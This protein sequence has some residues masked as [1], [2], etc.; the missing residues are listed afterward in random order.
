[1]VKRKI[2]PVIRNNK[3]NNKQGPAIKQKYAKKFFKNFDRR[4]LRV[5]PA[6]CRYRLN[7]APPKIFSFT[8]IMDNFTKNA[9]IK[10]AIDDLN[11]QLIPNFRG[12]AKI[13]SL[14]ESTLRRRFKGQTVSIKAAR[15]ATHQRLSIV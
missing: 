13:Y 10:L 15:A 8:K 1:M 14:V 11:R 6:A 2:K 4:S 5:L 9:S 7:A 3:F 12:T